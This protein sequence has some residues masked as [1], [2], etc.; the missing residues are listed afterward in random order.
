MFWQVTDTQREVKFFKNSYLVLWVAQS[1]VVILY[2]HLQFGILSKEKKF[3]IV[4]PLL[5]FSEL[6]LFWT[7]LCTHVKASFSDLSH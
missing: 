1:L 7:L 3:R 2:W 6:G 5:Q 4:K